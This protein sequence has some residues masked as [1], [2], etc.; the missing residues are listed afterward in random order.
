M[1]SLQ[2]IAQGFCQNPNAAGLDSQKPGRDAIQSHLESLTKLSDVW[3][4]DNAQTVGHT[5]QL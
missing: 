4:D 1:L 5:G 2:R 3:A